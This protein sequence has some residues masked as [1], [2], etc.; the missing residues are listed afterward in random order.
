MACFYISKQNPGKK[1]KKVNEMCLRKWKIVIVVAET[2][3]EGKRPSV[4]WR[5]YS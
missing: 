4:Y 1:G 2:S 3:R 5:S